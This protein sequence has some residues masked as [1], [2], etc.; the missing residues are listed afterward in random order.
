MTDLHDVPNLGKVL[1]EKLE[2]AGI[3][4]LEELKAV[5]SEKAFLRILA[6]DETACLNM[7]MALE[8]AME[9][10]RWHALSRA[11]KEELK[12]FF[13]QTKKK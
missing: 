9:G 10:I 1:I 6:F 5:G 3:H 11:R 12:H 7:L 2:Q 13:T 8:G 4:N